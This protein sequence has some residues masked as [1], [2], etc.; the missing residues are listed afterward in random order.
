MSFVHLHTHSEFSL[1][2]GMARIDQIIKKA[3]EYEMPAVAITDHGS[4]YGAFKFYIK[5]KD[6]G[7]KPI[8]GVELYKAK[9]TRFEKN[10]VADKDTNHQ[11]VIAKNLT[12]YQN[13]LKLVSAS[14]LEGFYYKPRVD[15]ELLEKYGEGL[16]A[17]SSCLGGEIPELILTNQLEQAEKVLKKYLEI[18]E[19]NYYIEIQ[20]HPQLEELEHVNSELIKL[21]KKYG[22]PLIATN[23]VHY[24]T[25]EDA[26]AQEVLLCIQTGTTVYEKRGLSMIDVPDYYFKSPAEMKGQFLDLPE[27]IEN[28]LKIAD[29]CNLE[30][31]HGKLIIPDYPIPES[32]TLESYLREMVYSKTD[33]IKGSTMEEI[34]KRL[35]YELSVINSKGYASYFL[36]VQDLVN[37]AKSNRIAVGPGRGSAA[38]ALVSYVLRIT[39][40]NPLDYNL[41]FERFLNP[42][43]PTPPDIDI[44][45]SDIRRDEVIKYVSEKYGED[46]VGQIITFGTMESKMAVRDVARALGLS[47][48][49]G[50]RLSKMIPQPKQGFHLSLS[51]AIQ[52]TPPLKLAYT[53]EEDTK[54]VFD[55]AMKLEGVPRHS[56]VHAAG[57][58]IADKP[59]TN[60]VPLQRDNKEGRIVTQ[61]DMYSLDLNAVSDNKAVGLMKVDF[62]GLRNLTTLEEALKFV[63][64]RTGTLID[65]HEVPLDDKKTYELMSRGDTIG[66]FQLE[67]GGMRRLAKD[68]QPEKLT[69]IIAMVAL[70]RPGPMDLI[71]TFIEGRKNPKKIKYP[72]PDLKGILG[73][74]YGILVYQEQVIDI[75]VHLAKFTKSEADLLRMAVGKK[76]KS[77]MEKG[78][79]Q[80][81]AGAVA[82]GYKKALAENIF[83]FI[84]K[85]AS[86]GFN[87]AHAACYAL[88]AYWTAYM[89]ANYPVEFMT[90][91]LTSELLGAAGPMKEVKMSQAL[92]E[93]KKM[94]IKVLTPDVNK[95]VSNFSIENKE[96]RF[97]LSAIKNVG[98]AAIDSIVEARKDGEFVSFKDFLTR[99]ELRKV[100]K[101]TVESLIKAG[102]F[103]QFANRATLLAYYPYMVKEVADH[104]VSQDKGQFGLFQD[105]GVTIK[106]EDNFSEIPELTEMEIC[107]YEKEVI[108]FLISRNPLDTYKG[109]IDKKITKKIGEL[110]LEDVKKVVVLAGIVTGKKVV[111]TKKDNAEMSFLNINDQSGSL[112][113]VVFPKIY[114]KLKDILNVNKVILFKGV[115]SDRD[116]SVSVMMDNAVDLERI[117]TN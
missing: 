46:K 111:K 13:L 50:D 116:G 24:V 19:G 9:K 106:R 69:D 82:H 86:Y 51:D 22:V 37:W 16:I 7:I 101:K 41:A 61:Y 83:F 98:S 26:Y 12:G 74:T 35:D 62:L 92:E 105:Q 78:R 97:G 49:Q 23:D 57:V 28:T 60:Y 58:I 63:Q 88:I 75:A 30:I 1:L 34:T 42:E 31:P 4:L 84:E 21:S 110:V 18:F 94:G 8:I 45:F 113:V 117:S 81:I 80:F 104:R 72:H 17:T 38:G 65:I 109:V 96:I 55:I 67:S 66:V 89:K 40:I 29:E 54:K 52:E 59:L 53:T 56:S 15:W 102:A 100:N 90:A 91:L 108:G 79:K 93:C 95:S 27:A 76:K 103:H 47:Y 6:A 73:E 114:A 44:D 107:T 11:L 85:F 87:K 64:D 10:G 2:D 48:A 36:L 14:N 70:Y 99:V 20:R 68:L 77:L 33:R 5:A 112:E 71:P 32:H 39:D 3:Q 43:R 115:V 25:K